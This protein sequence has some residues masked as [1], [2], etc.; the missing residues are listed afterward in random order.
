MIKLTKGAT[1]QVLA[2]NYE[3]WTQVLVDKLAKGEEPTATEKSRYRHAD[4]KEALVVETGG[5]CAYCECKIRHIAY[6]D[7]EHICPKSLDPALTFRWGNLTLACDVCNT[8]KSDH[9]KNPDDFVDPYQVDPAQHLF[10][11]GDILMAVP[12]SDRGRLTEEILD[13]NRVELA[14]RRKERLKNLRSQ[15]ETCVRTQNPQLRQIL[16]Q[17]IINNETSAE[18]EFVA[19]SRAFIAAAMPAP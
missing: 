8:N 5:K 16:R 17:D 12:G 15:I 9:F 14:E 19:M 10:F 3:Y 4:I 7:V 11:F 18:K 13:L 2:D 6:G 1:P